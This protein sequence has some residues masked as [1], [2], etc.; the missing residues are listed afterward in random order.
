MSDDVAVRKVDQENICAFSILAEELKAL[1]VELKDLEEDKGALADV[2]DEIILTEHL[3]QGEGMFY[4][5]GDTFVELD[6]SRFE[7]VIA[8]EK[9]RT[10][11]KI[12]KTKARIEEL[13]EKMIKLKTDLYARF[14]EQIALEFE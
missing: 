14:R 4:R 8:E 5:Y 11:Y 13:Q 12:T 6:D 2:E 1:K 9:A 7:E 10:Q 3:R